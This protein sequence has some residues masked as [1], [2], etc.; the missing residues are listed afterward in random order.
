[1][2]K[3]MNRVLTLASV[4]FTFIFVGCTREF[5]KTTLSAPTAFK[6]P[7]LE[8]ISDVVVDKNNNKVEAV[9]FNW[10][11]ADFGA[12]TQVEYV[13]YLRNGGNTGRLGSSFAN[14]LTVSKG[15]I[16]ALATGDLNIAKNETA[17]VE[18]FLVASVYGTDAGSVESN[19]ITFNVT[20][21]DAPKDCIYLPGFYNGWV[22]EKTDMWEMEGGSKIYRMLVKLAVNENGDAPFKMS[23]Y[24]TWTGLNDGYTADWDA[25]FGDKDGNLSVPAEELIN[26]I[27]VNVNEKKVYRE[28]VTSMDII[29]GFAAS[30][31]WSKPVLF[32]YD[33]DANVWK[34]E[35]LAFAAGDEFLIRL[36]GNW[37]AKNKYGTA[38]APSSEIPG[39]FELEQS[40]DASNV[41]CAEAGTYVV[42]VYA[43]HTPF[44]LVMEKQ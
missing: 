42:K 24:G 11:P 43:N 35:P 14:S 1:M 3:I 30:E 40:G 19:A 2:K 6:A 22:Q 37:D 18:A 27:T 21:F 9:T 36:N 38:T 23:I 26:F 34:T 31:G 29:G 25:D 17:P 32:D 39:G 7:T 20:T 33:V 12:P 13:L 28:H 8:A 15:D 5:E 4:L 44:V 41:V 10:S 16:N